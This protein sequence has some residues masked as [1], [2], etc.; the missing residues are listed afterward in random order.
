MFSFHFISHSWNS[1]SC[2]IRFSF[3]KQRYL[4]S[5][6]CILSSPCGFFS[7]IIHHWN[8]I[9]TRRFH[10]FVF[11]PKTLRKSFYQRFDIVPRFLSLFGENLR[12]TFVKKIL[13]EFPTYNF[14]SVDQRLSSL[15]ESR[16]LPLVS[17]SCSLLFSA[18]I[19][20]F[21]FV[22]NY[23]FSFDDSR[24]PLYNF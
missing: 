15:E 21:V 4:F 23:F 12:H 19:C 6:F 3:F 1:V 17:S 24:L 9:F 13:H 7:Q 18:K 20:V 22:F 16:K 2:W 11:S 8:L 14:P 10:L 5:A